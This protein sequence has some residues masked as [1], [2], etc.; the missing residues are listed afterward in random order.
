[1][2]S[3]LRNLSHTLSW[4]DFRGQ[5]PS[6]ASLNAQTAVDIE[7]T[8]L[9]VERTSSGVRLRDNVI[10]TIALKHNQSWAKQNARTAALL[11]HEQGHYH[12]TAL[13]GRDMFIDLMQLKSQTFSGDPALQSEFNGIRARYNAQ[14]MHD[15]YDARSETDH[16]RDSAKQR[17]WDGYFQRAR[18]H[19]RSPRLVAP[20][21]AVYKVRLRDVLR[22]A[23][24]I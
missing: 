20:D 8:R 18:T 14:A 12:I 23:G 7:F 16:G 17:I 22:A 19:P 15:K 21:G 13:T 6:N 11:N 5:V 9:E 1:M 2:P 3:V 24:K 10:L 4:S